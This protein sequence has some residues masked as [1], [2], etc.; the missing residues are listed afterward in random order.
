MVDLEVCFLFQIPQFTLE[1][2]CVAETG[3]TDK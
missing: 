3:E 2:L 1:L